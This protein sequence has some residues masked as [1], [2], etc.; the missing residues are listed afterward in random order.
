LLLRDLVVSTAL[1]VGAEDSRPPKRALAETP[2]WE[3]VDRIGQSRLTQALKKVIEL[4]RSRAEFD[5]RVGSLEFYGP[6]LTEEEL[7]CLFEVYGSCSCSCSERARKEP[8]AQKGLLEERVGLPSRVESRR[9]ER[10][11]GTWDSRPEGP[12]EPRQA[13]RRRGSRSRGR[14][15]VRR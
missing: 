13:R 5:K 8:P 3:R 12:R 15:S 1:L 10:D 6:D 7:D 9:G 2:G 4:G 11:D 14:V